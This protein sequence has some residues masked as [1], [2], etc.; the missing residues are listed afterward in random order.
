MAVALR[1][2]EHM[3]S[4]ISD[5]A[6]SNRA[7]ARLPAGLQHLH[8]RRVLLGHRHA[9]VAPHRLPPRRRRLL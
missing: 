9:D 8:R 4:A 5:C 3:R 7:R 6:A 2:Q 1:S